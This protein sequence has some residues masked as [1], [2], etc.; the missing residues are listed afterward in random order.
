[1]RD[2]LAAGGRFPDLE[3]PDH[4]GAELSLTAIADGQP[5]VLCFVRGWWCPK[6]QVRLRGLVSMQEEIQREYGR[7]AVV[8]VDEPYVNGAFRAGLGAEFPSSPTTIAASPRSSTCSSS[9][10]RS[11]ART[12]RSRS[13][14]TRRSAS[15]G[16]GAASGTGGTR[17]PTSCD[18]RSARSP[19]ASNR[20][21]TPSASGHGEAPRPQR[22]GSRARRSG[23]GRTGRGAS[24]RAASTRATFLRRARSSAA[25]RSTG[26]R[27]SSTR[28]RGRTAVWRSAPASTAGRRRRASSATT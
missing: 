9:P 15:T 6:E 12:C 3:L 4:T 14:S 2:D 16:S 27:G 20:H 1:M 7:L 18:G 21:S 11:T 22:R 8:T 24:S 26:G 10:T 25:R 23:C 5:L 17:R 28:W 19:A 13:S